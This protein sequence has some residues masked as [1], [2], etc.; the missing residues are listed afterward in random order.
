MG[1]VDYD[2]KIKRERGHV[3]LG[4]TGMEVEGNEVLMHVPVAPYIVTR[5]PGMNG[6]LRVRVSDT[7]IEYLEAAGVPVRL[8]VEVPVEKV[9]SDLG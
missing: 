2:I 9:G 4:V 8:L 7:I 5:G 6:E 3:T 1:L